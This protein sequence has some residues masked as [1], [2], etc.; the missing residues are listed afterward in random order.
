MIRLKILKL[1]V[2]IL[3]LIQFLILISCSEKET[4]EQDIFLEVSERK[5]FKVGYDG[6]YHNTFT[7]VT[8]DS[9]GEKGLIYNY[10]N[11]SL[12][13]IFISADSAWS[14]TGEP[15][16][17]EGPFGVG[18]MNSFFVW[19]D[20]IIIFTNSELFFKSI[21]TGEVRKKLLISYPF[22]KDQKFD[23][24]GSSEIYENRF[25]SFD[26]KE[27]KAYF[28]ISNPIEK[29]FFAVLMDLK[30]G[31]F[32]KVPVYLDSVSLK[33]MSF[34]TSIA[35]GKISA[36]DDPVMRLIGNRL[37]ITYPAF[38]DMINYELDE[39]TQSGFSYESSSFPSRRSLPQNS[40]EKL[41]IKLALELL[42]K[43]QDQ[44][45]FGPLGYFQDSDLFFRFV[46]GEKQTTSNNFEQLFLEIF[47][48]D[49]QKIDEK[50]ISQLYPDLSRQYLQTK[51]GLMVKAKDQPKENVMYYYNL[52]IRRSK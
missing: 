16:E 28:M 27:D 43:W 48:K 3:A 36:P 47:S 11:H 44:V 46:K 8:L 24:I 12:D 13:S 5:E 18:R 40:Q 51:H 23:N 14:K 21:K 20:T 9:L 1:K 15:M 22:F 33:A 38:S 19:Q 34:S 45:S 35:N 25:L 30:E 50:N 26:A 7:P 32:E 4:F 49:L 42:G 2:K 52:N 39:K 6:L 37:Y 29:S 10:L 41:E 31:K 17:S